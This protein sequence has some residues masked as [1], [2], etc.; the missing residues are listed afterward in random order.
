[1]EKSADEEIIKIKVAEG[2]NK[3]I[4]VELSINTK[5]KIKKEE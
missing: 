4:V 2:V 3:Q 5:R 1:M